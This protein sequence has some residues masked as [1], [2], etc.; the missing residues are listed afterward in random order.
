M[1]LLSDLLAR[2]FEALI[3]AGAT[4]LVAAFLL[5]SFGISV[6]RFGAEEHVYARSVAMYWTGYAFIVFGGLVFVARSLQAL[7]HRRRD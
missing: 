4:E 1:D 7:F 2:G 6:A 5:V 3:K